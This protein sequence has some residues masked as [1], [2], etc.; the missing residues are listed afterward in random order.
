MRCS[1]CS[2]QCEK[3]VLWTALLLTASDDFEIIRGS[4]TIRIGDYF[5]ALCGEDTTVPGM[6]LEFVCRDLGFWIVRVS[7]LSFVDLAC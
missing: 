5:L 2:F 7:L 6:F 4:T 3:D 1:P